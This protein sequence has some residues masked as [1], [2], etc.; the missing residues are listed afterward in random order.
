MTGDFISSTL[1]KPGRAKLCDTTAP[2][3]LH[4]LA[5]Y[6]WSFVLQTVANRAL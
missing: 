3:A 1:V 2:A 6:G 5:R 4:G